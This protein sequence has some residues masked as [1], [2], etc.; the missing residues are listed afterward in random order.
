MMD[1]ERM[2]DQ[3]DPGAAG[4]AVEGEIVEEPLEDAAEQVEADRER[5]LR[6]AAEFDNFRKRTE[7]EMAEFKKRAAD[8][9]L[10]ALLEV[11]DNLDRALETAGSCDPADLV[12]GLGAIRS[13]MG[14]ILS[15][16]GI[17]P[18]GAVGKTFDPFE[19]E[20]V[21]RMPSPEI[22]EGNVVRELCQG[23]RG[24]GYVLR[25]SKVI[26][27]SGPPEVEDGRDGSDDPRSHIDDQTRK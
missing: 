14:A 21:M 16:E 24:Q 20:A 22:G 2:K 13:Q 10:L 18:I 1:V 7:R 27:S 4:Q 26:V 17:E 19:M 9:I 6:L 8:D 12:K 25:P 23:Y 3:E 11:V 15:R 5:Y